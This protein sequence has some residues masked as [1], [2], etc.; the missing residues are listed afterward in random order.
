MPSEST[1]ATKRMHSSALSFLSACFA[2]GLKVSWSVVIVVEAP[3]APAWREADLVHAFDGIVVVIGSEGV[4]VADARP[5]SRRV[6]QRGEHERAHGFGAGRPGGLVESQ[7]PCPPGW[8]R[9]ITSLRR[10]ARP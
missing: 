2:E 10:A 8:S 5:R 6:E 1:N 3:P 9:C 7:R 4:V